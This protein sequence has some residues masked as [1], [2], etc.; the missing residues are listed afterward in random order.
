MKILLGKMPH[1]HESPLRYRLA[2]FDLNQALGGEIRITHTGRILCTY[3]GNQTPKSFG[4]GY[5]YPCFTTLARADSCI[6]RPHTCHFGRGTCREPDWGKE[7]CMIPHVAYLALTTLVK[8]GVTGA[9]RTLAR[10]GDQGARAAVVLA[11]APDRRT[12]GLIEAALAKK[13]PDRTNWRKLITGEPEPVDLLAEKQ[14]AASLVPEALSQ[15]LAD[16]DQVTQFEYPVRQY[17]YKARTRNL[18]KENEIRGVLN[19]IK[20]QYLLIE[21]FAFNIRRHSGYEVDLEIFP[22]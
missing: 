6:I 21:D 3:C 5:C 18:D 10:W 22:P 16:Q 13:M 7:H 1:E 9:H 19:G 15:Y 2:D 12:A 11:V 14:R 17:P 20:G 8:V 4:D